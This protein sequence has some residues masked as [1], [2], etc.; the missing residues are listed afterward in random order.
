MNSKA[1]NN[2]LD[3]RISFIQSIFRLM[4]LLNILAAF[5]S[6]VFAE[7]RL[8]IQFISSDDKVKENLVK[9]KQVFTD[10]LSRMNELKRVKNDIVAAG[11]LATSIDSLNNIDS[12]LTAFVNTGKIYKWAKLSKGNVDER[13]LNET[14]RS[15]KRFRNQTITPRDFAVTQ[16]AIV[17]WYENH[18]YPFAVITLDS[19][20]AKENILSATFKLTKNDLIKI[21][22]IIVRGTAKL[23]QIYLL[24]YLSIRIGDLYNESVIRNISTRLKE[25]PMVAE[26]K[27]FTVE[28]EGDKAIL[29]LFLDNR[30][31]SQ[32][33]G[34]IGLLPDASNKGKLTVSGDVRLR[35]I[36]AFG[37][38]E[39]VEIN[40]KQPA[41]KTQ[42]LKTRVNYPFLLSSPF[43]VEGALNIYKKDTTYL[44]VILSGA[45]QYLLKGN[46]YL[47]AFVI[48]KKSSLL[49]T[50][51][52]VNA[53]V[54]PSYADVSVTSYGLGYK[55]EKLDYRISPH[56]GYSF[57]IT[58]SA[59]NKNIAKNSNLNDE[60]YKNVKLSSA[61]YNGEYSIDVYF[62]LARKVVLN[63]GS[64]G[65]YLSSQETFQNELYR[66]GGLKTL[67]G[68][69]EESLF[70]SQFYMVKAEFRY[71]LD[72][73]S[74]LQTFYNQAYYASQTRDN[75]VF[76]T[77]L[78]FGAGITFE[79][80][81]GIFSLNY[82]LGK[83]FNNPIQFRSAKVHFGIVN[84]F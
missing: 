77:P 39:Q 12:T 8:K 26:T 35:L 24:N 31:A 67:R 20:S 76:D 2:H 27:P 46:N 38:G 13:V 4:V 73:N 32:A 28:F 14:G 57:E 78:G 9:Y 3:K 16:K 68:F 25:L 81:I 50:S 44:D 71:L 5:P 10:S 59:G 17:T 42:D 55:M 72:R 63:A 40:W 60:L 7:Y 45:I 56:K 51:S 37:R 18:G 34:I 82:A 22:T 33:D 62:P 70:A 43:G 54:L 53:T 15:E 6:N 47:K 74:Y 29:T 79:T 65:A 48:N 1:N 61:Q 52:L 84:Y 19:M 64:K 80:R 11:Y 21:D 66:F 49:S 69:D 23:K 58:G 30:K 36:S 75:S 41:P 83:Q